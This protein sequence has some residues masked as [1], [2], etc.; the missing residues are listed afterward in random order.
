MPGVR[1]VAQSRDVVRGK[2]PTVRLPMITETA[3]FVVFVVVF[4]L[5]LQFLTDY[6]RPDRSHLGNSLYV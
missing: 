5:D 3:W 6:G 4:W 1:G 2:W